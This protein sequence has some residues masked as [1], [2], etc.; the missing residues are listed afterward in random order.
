MNNAQVAEAAIRERTSGQ[1][2][3]FGGEQGGDEPLR[4]TPADPWSRTER[5]AQERENFGF[6]FSAH[7]VQQYRQAASAQGARSYQSIMEA[8][9]PPGGRGHAVIAAMVEG[10]SK[11]RT[12]R[13]G[14]FV[15]GDFSDA[16][17]QFSAACFE[18]ALVP[19][20]ERW[21]K[22]GECL[23]LS[24]ELDSPNPGEPPRLTVRG[25][26]PL[27]QVSGR[28]PMRLQAD[29]LTTIAFEAFRHELQPG[30]E[31]PGE[32]V[33]R[34]AMASGEDATVRLGTGFQLDGEM[35]ERIAAIEG[36]ANVRLEPVRGSAR[37]KLVA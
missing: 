13:G 11:G 17:G 8:G 25:A 37:L 24:V 6:Y 9:A 31:A 10:M 30:S 20:F 26:K 2:G 32:V 34:L 23:L 35:A 4:L 18:E 21:A 22:S 7:P 27:E 12:K 16:S 19:E 14:E 33:V 28:M 5:M 3:L 15:R 36:I 29:I 1:G